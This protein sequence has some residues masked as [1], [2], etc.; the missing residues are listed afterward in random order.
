MKSDNKII[1]AFPLSSMQSGMY[2]HYMLEERNTLYHDVFRFSIECRWNEPAFLAAIHTVLGRHPILRTAFEFEKFSEPMQLVYQEGIARF[3]VIDAQSTANY[4]QLIAQTIKSLQCDEFNLN[5]PSLIRF[6][7]AQK[8][9]DQFDLLVDA[10][11][12]ILDGWSM[13]L[14]LTELFQSYLHELGVVPGAL[15][16]PSPTYLFKTFVKQERAI[17]SDPHASGYWD[18]YLSAWDYQPL[19][20]G[21]I[22]AQGD[23]HTLDFELEPTLGHALKQVAVNH[24]TSLRS[25]LLAAHLRTCAFIQGAKMGAS[26]VVNNSRLEQLGGDTAVGLF[27]NSLPY[28]ID[29]TGIS[30]RELLSA[31]DQTQARHYQHRAFP[32]AQMIKAH[33]HPISDILFNYVHFH[34]YEKIQGIDT[35]KV[36]NVSIEEKNN[37]GLAITFVQDLQGNIRILLQYDTHIIAPNKINALVSYLTNA[38][39]LL[40]DNPDEP[41]LK[42]SLLNADEKVK[43]IQASHSAEQVPLSS[44]RI[45]ELLADSAGQYAERTALEFEHQTM[46][47]R[48]LDARAT[49]VAQFLQSNK[50]GAGDLV[51]LCVERSFELIIAVLGIIKAGAA[52]LPLDVSLPDE[53]KR[54]IV[55]DAK[56]VLCLVQGV[57]A[58]SLQDVTTLFDI[59]QACL[60]PDGADSSFA[61]IKNDACVQDPVF[62]LYTSGTTGKPKGVVMSHQ[63]MTNLVFAQIKHNPLL[64]QGLRTLQFASIGF[65]ASF[66]ELVTTLIWGGTLC[67]VSETQRKDIHQLP[68]F[69]QIHQIERLFIPY[70]ALK[71]LCMSAMESAY[72][73]WPLKVI[74]TAGEQLQMTAELVEWLSSIP[75]LVLDN[76]Y[77]PTETHVATTYHNPEPLKLWSFLPPIGKPLANC[78]A[79]VLD[80]QRAL[81]PDGVVGELYLGGVCLADGY[82]NAPQQSAEKFIAHPYTNATGARLYKTGDRVRRDDQGHLVFIGRI[83]DQIKVRGYRVEPAEIEHQLNQLRQVSDALVIA[84]KDSLGFNQLVA[85]VLKAKQSHHNTKD[86]DNENI[87]LTQLAK[88]LPDYMIPAALMILDE[89]PLTAN[90]KLDKRALPAL[91]AANNKVSYQPPRN[92]MEQDLAAIWSELLALPLQSIGVNDN[93]FTLGGHS[94]LVVRLVAKIN[95]LLTISVKLHSIFECPTIAALAQQLIQI[96]K[97]SEQKTTEKSEPKTST[98]PTIAAVERNAEHYPLSFSQQRLWIIDKIQQGSANY[99]MPARIDIKGCFNVTLA[100]QAINQLIQRHEILRTHFIEVQD[101]ARQVINPHC[102]LVIQQHDVS[103]MSPVAGAAYIADM[104]LKD[105]HQAF[106]LAQPPLLRVQWF[107]CAEHTS[108]LLFNMH[109]IVS[110]G[111]SVNVL[112]RE[113]VECYQALSEQRAAR[114]P[115]LAIQYVDYAFWQKAYLNNEIETDQITYWARQLAQAPITHN[116][117]LDYARGERIE[118]GVN[119][120]SLSLPETLCRQINQFSQA[121]QLTDFMFF[122]G[123]LVVLIAKYSSVGDVVIGTAVANRLNAELEALVGFFVN[124]LALRAHYQPNLSVAQFFALIRTVNIDAQSNQDVPFEHL[125]THINVPRSTAHTPLFQIMLSMNN[126]PTSAL[127]LPGLSFTV[128]PV[129]QPTK[130]DLDI[131]IDLPEHKITWQFD[132]S[133]FSLARVQQLAGLYQQVLTLLLDDQ[134]LLKNIGLNKA[135]SNDV[136]HAFLHHEAR[137]TPPEVLHA[138]FERQV[139]RAPHSIALV[140]GLRKWTY[141]ELNSRAN[142]LAHYLVQRGLNSE[143]KIGLLCGRNSHSFIALLGVLKAGAAYVPIDTD[144]PL[145]RISKII[146]R[147]DIRWLLTEHAHA[148]TAAAQTSVELIYVDHAA[149]F[150]SYP[151]ETPCISVTPDQLAY[152]IFTSGSTGQPKGVMIE[153]RSI[154]AHINALGKALQLTSA[155]KYLL[156]SSLAFDAAV[157]QIFIPWSLGASCV[158]VQ[159]NQ[160]SAHELIQLLRTQEISVLDLPPAYWRELV[161]SDLLVQQPLT[162]VHSVIL[163]GEAFPVGS[164]SFIEKKFPAVHSIYNAYGPTE[165]TVTALLNRCDPSALGSSAPVPLGRAFDTTEIWVLDLDGNVLPDGAVGELCIGGNRLARGYLH[166]PEQTAL[167][168][169]ESNELGARRLYRTGDLV[170]KSLTGEL[171]FCGRI[172]AQIKL[173]GFRIEIAEIEYQ[174]NAVPEVAQCSVVLTNA[175]ATPALSA[176]VRF[177]HNQIL[178]PE[179][180]R[181]RL[182]QHLPDYMLPRTIV[183]VAQWPLTQNGKTDYIQLA[184]LAKTHTP[185]TICSPRTHLEQCL[186]SLYCDVL[187]LTCVD[188]TDSF[189]ELGGHSILAVRLVNRIVAELNRPLALR[190][191]MENPRIID[192]AKIIDALPV[193]ST[194]ART[195]ATLSEQDT[196]NRHQPFPLTGIQ[197]SYFM[198]RRS[199][200]SLGNVGA[201]GYAELPAAYLDVARVERAWNRLIERHD[202]LR[203]VVTPSG[204]QIILPQVPDYKIEHVDLSGHSLPTQRA[205]LSA[206]RAAMSHQVFSGMEWPLFDLRVT[207][208]SDQEA[209]LH[210]GTDA[211]AMDASSTMLIE[212][213]FYQLYHEPEAILTPI[214]Y[215]FREYVLTLKQQESTDIFIQAKRYWM[216]KIAEFPAA[217]S[218]PLALDPERIETPIFERRAINLPRES[219]ETIKRFSA[220]QDI[221]PTALVLGCFAKVINQWAEQ[222]NFALNLTLFNRQPFHPEVEHIVGDFTALTLLAFASTTLNAPLL[223][224]L[225]KT[226]QQLW[227]DVEHSAY[228][229]TELL[230]D[231][232]RHHGRI[233]SYPIVFT[234]TLGLESSAE[235][236]R[237]DMPNAPTLS[238]AGFSISQTSQVWLDCQVSETEGALDCVWDSVEGLFK[239]HVLDDMIS[240]LHALLMQIAEHNRETVSVEL[241]A[242]QRNLIAEVNDTDEHFAQG[243]LHEPLLDS[244]KKYPEKIAVYTRHYQLTYAELNWRS[245]FIASQLQQQGVRTNELVA[246]VLEKG[247]QQIVAVLGILR[248]GAAYLPIDG[249]LPDARIQLLIAAGKVSQVITTPEYLPKLPSNAITHLIDPQQTSESINNLH[250][251]DACSTKNTDLAYVIFTSGSTGMPKGVMIDH[252]GARNTIE[253]I[254]KRLA[255]TDKDVVFG[256]SNLNF[257]L[258]VYDIFGVLGAGGSIV[259]P[260][261]KEYRDPAAWLAYLVPDTLGMPVIT[262]W[263][264]VP[265]LMQMLVEYVAS[266]RLVDVVFSFE[267]ILLSG[268]W[269][270]TDLP[271]KIWTTCTPKKLLSLGGATEAS[272][273][274]IYYPI[275]PGEQFSTSVPYG[276]PLAN[277]QFY[278]LKADLSLAPVEV[279]GDLYISGIGVAKGYWDDQEKTDASFIYHQR[280]N[281]TLY[282]TGDKGRLRADGQ[283]EFLGREDFQVK[284]QGYRIELGEIETR[285]KKHPLVNDVFVSTYQHQGQINLIAYYTDLLTV[286]ASTA[287][288]LIAFKQTNHGLAL[289]SSP[290]DIDISATRYLSLAKHRSDSDNSSAWDFSAAKKI[291]HGFCRHKDEKHLI[292]KAF[293]PSAGST[294]AVQT[295]VCIPSALNW[296]DA[297][298]KP[299]RGVFYLNPLEWCLQPVPGDL[300]EVDQFSLIL[301]GELAAI[302]PLYQQYAPRFLALEAGYM[303]GLANKLCPPNYRLVARPLTPDTGLSQALR[304]TDSQY[305]VGVHQINADVAQRFSLPT[306][307]SAVNPAQSLTMVAETQPDQLALWQRKSYRKYLSVPC[308]HLQI[309]QIFSALRAEAERAEYTAPLDIYVQ[310][311]HAIP[312]ATKNLDA[313]IYRYDLAQHLLTLESRAHENI[314]NDE[315]W[316]IAELAAFTIFFVSSDNTSAQWVGQLA[317]SIMLAGV[318]CHIGI[319][320][321]GN[322]DAERVTQL[323]PNGKAATVIHSLSCG[324]IDDIELHST[325]HSMPV[326]PD[327]APLLSTHLAVYLPSYMVPKHFM[328]MPNLPLTANGKIDRAALPTPQNMAPELWEDFNF[329]GLAHSLRASWC[330]VLGITELQPSDNFF[331]LGGH[332][333]AAVRLTALLKEQLGTTLSI[334]Q[335]FENPTFFAMLNALEKIVKNTAAAEKII[336]NSTQ[337]NTEDEQAEPTLWI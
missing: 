71:I 248:A 164:F 239:E 225:K 27:V 297:T 285:L 195:P 22:E 194:T 166:D 18:K 64:G 192:L 210:I 102:E 149:Q 206:T 273:W 289:P 331:N 84:Q 111:W 295:F 292:A 86:A 332:S 253:D 165:T 112:I 96:A 46:S 36:S 291:L 3:D 143:E 1:D 106:D 283:I 175:S 11:H 287:G 123:A 258:S 160:L 268:D 335:V 219:W 240:A 209:I 26:L 97:Q 236:Q 170:R 17:I 167:H 257:D 20:L 256:L 243:L 98:T 250:F 224:C 133:I 302:E 100:E 139:I 87:I 12:M 325:N 83:D 151:I 125:L 137:H 213:E 196:A 107:Q 50:V 307:T 32:I 81:V 38:L 15:E 246:V 40:V 299:I 127:E 7:I 134:L 146:T 171:Y 202:M 65:D 122:H 30:W 47:Y 311:N 313:G 337:D 91:T 316:V 58:S 128:A 152:V 330:E 73:Y 10:H 300:P 223:E 187:E 269:I 326:P 191:L 142:Q 328:A 222:P 138:A 321:M 314:F 136:S 5:L 19:R 135:E 306:P 31:I 174:L 204:E 85:Y 201:Y 154:S 67:L 208:L 89:W 93:F 90:G 312:T 180:L 310:I 59:K 315:N 317:Q 24:K 263:N 161:A 150:E 178:S 116:L 217:P 44:K 108:V 261:V 156:F 95:K 131:D 74:V 247:W 199:D 227:M 238:E 140:C 211:L 271:E 69:I 61:K 110:D 28:G 41:C 280:L 218:L 68:E 318:M 275:Q 13:A 197:K 229:G 179:V 294:Y 186:V 189:F 66:H 303:L 184:E 309:S 234:S 235:L 272:I 198:G 172:D 78:E 323:L 105:S 284:V 132:P 34:V 215:S 305:I 232:M 286:N 216:E 109:H 266:H 54:I 9:P 324:V 114:L 200:F 296:S 233:V 53:R 56:P 145:E 245:Q 244:L 333:L 103:E 220:Q 190:Q 80:E 72:Q 158:V 113:F 124:T 117:P 290:S 327:M 304:L 336:A 49:Q 183:A 75:H 308:T 115:A 51:G 62:C 334:A 147:A 130:F 181:Q 153:H 270:P 265:A 254:N 92:E 76:H 155:E 57:A 55:M 60:N 230:T 262:L 157:E 242:W 212:R 276:K 177:E 251:S 35:F 288:E 188:I 279:A 203:M 33:A 6:T 274:S 79:W 259:L 126:V 301:V 298:G 182:Q 104:S 207:T 205:H 169:F 129:V 277:Q 120:Y 264:T 282:K 37:A 29:L 141:A 260:E 237:F 281:K 173:R 228:D 267:S 45:D 278:V 119:T 14:L 25:V 322:V 99:N 293:Y 82:L 319:C 39:R 163:G 168:F 21:D 70:A 88:V 77:G 249:S 159:D 23:L 63:A 320:P 43:I 162:S 52:Y 214:K 185:K 221:T 329:T 8:T 231:L 193:T 48:E 121:H 101:Q 118:V 255:L 148:D 226:Q 176:Y 252:A 241:P 42:N 94:L 2:Y 4:P 16:S 144:A